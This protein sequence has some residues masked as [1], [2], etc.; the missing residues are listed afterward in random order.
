MKGKFGGGDGSALNPYI[1]EDDFD[2]FAMEYQHKFFKLNQNISV[3]DIKKHY[4]F[5]GTLL[6]NGFELFLNWEDF[7]TDKVFWC[8]G[9]IFGGRVIFNNIAEGVEKFIGGVVSHCELIFK[10]KN[11]FRMTYPGNTIFNYCK[12]TWEPINTDIRGMFQ[13]NDYENRNFYNTLFVQ[14]K[15]AF[16]NLDVFLNLDPENKNQVRLVHPGNQIVYSKQLPKTNLGEAIAW[17]QSQE[18]WKND[19][20]WWEFLYLTKKKKNW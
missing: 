7:D 3:F 20:L 2:F 6:L 16:N 1:I 15:G 11:V 14:P 8:M 13:N 4:F 9:N 12:I 18:F 5:Y 10:E 17:T 19:K